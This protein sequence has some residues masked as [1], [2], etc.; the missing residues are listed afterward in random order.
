VM[1]YYTFSVKGFQENRHNFATNARAIQEQREEKIIGEIPEKYYDELA[2]F[3]LNVQ[4]MVENINSLRK[5]TNL[6]FLG[7]DRNVMNLPGLGKSLTFRSIGITNDGR[8]ILKFNHDQN[9]K[10]S[11]IADQMG[12]VVIVESKSIADYL[13][14]ME[15]MGEDMTEY[16]SLYGYSMGSTEPRVPIYKYPDYD[17]EV[18]KE[19][20][21]FEIALPTEV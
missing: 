8:R 19:L 11:P 1:T 18:T 3:P 10:H 6:P 9:R 16:N 14:Q 15:K 21:N 5:Q 17:F 20:T 7:T 12:K 2:T 4:H 13:D